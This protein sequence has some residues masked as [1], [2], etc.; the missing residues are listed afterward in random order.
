VGNLDPRRDFVDVRDAARAYVELSMREDLSG[1]PYNVASGRAV[2]IRTLLDLALAAAG[3]RAEVI[4]DPARVR[5]VDVPEQVGDPR[6][7]HAA[8]GWSA[9]IPLAASIRDMG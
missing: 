2:A 6:R 7:L 8:T 1:R 5:P 9:E 3:V 4:V